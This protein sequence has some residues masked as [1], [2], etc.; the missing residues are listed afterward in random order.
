MFSPTIT[1]LIHVLTF[2]YHSFHFVTLAFHYSPQNVSV[3]YN[4]YE[5]SYIPYNSQTILNCYCQFELLATP[6]RLFSFGFLRYTI[7]SFLFILAYFARLHFSELPWAAYT[8]D[9]STL[10]SFLPS[11]FGSVVASQVASCNIDITGFSAYK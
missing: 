6:I 11:T 5:C 2:I 1:V 4:K 3:L 9:K 8:K 10:P 7:Y